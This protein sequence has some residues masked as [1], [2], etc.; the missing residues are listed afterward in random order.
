MND[1]LHMIDGRVYMTTDG[2]R[3]ITLKFDGRQR[4]VVGREADNVRFLAM[5]QAGTTRN[6]NVETGR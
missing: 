1:D 4:R 3:T 2:W 5:V 6:E